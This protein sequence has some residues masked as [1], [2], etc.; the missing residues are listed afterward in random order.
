MASTYASPS[1]STVDLTI[2]NS[3]FRD[4]D[5]AAKKQQSNQRPVKGGEDGRRRG[6]CPLLVESCL[7]HVPCRGKQQQRQNVEGNHLLVLISHSL[8]LNLVLHYTH[9]LPARALPLL[10]LLQL[11]ICSSIEVAG[12]TRTDIH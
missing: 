5:A 4:N 9:R 2:E 11:L 6:T 12:L 8:T 1:T 7:N 10:Q 3:L